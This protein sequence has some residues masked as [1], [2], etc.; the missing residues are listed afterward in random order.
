MARLTVSCAHA[1]GVRAVAHDSAILDPFRVC[2]V[3][4]TRT[5]RAAG[6]SSKLLGPVSPS[7]LHGERGANSLSRPAASTAV[8][9]RMK[10][11]SS[12]AS[13]RF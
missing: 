4:A 1:K 2:G 12:Q 13:L 11:T 9:A 10:N 8:A 7:Q 3:Q 5:V 6:L